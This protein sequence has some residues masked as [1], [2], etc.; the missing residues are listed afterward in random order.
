MSLRHAARVADGAR[1]ILRGMVLTLMVGVL[2][3]VA[4]Q[5]ITRYV[6]GNPW[7]WTE[8]AARYCLVWLTFLGAALLAQEGG[9]IA[10][11]L[12]GGRRWPVLDALNRVIQVVGAAGLSY[13]G[14]QYAQLVVGTHS[15]ALRMPMEWVY[16]PAAVGFGLW[17][18]SALG[19]LVTGKPTVPSSVTADAP[20]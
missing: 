9:H 11:D 2:S 20:S 15:A 6:V 3:L 13:G 18:L 1:F 12:A 14:W 19:Q 7:V 5:V 4:M 8:E 10:V 16:L 17:A